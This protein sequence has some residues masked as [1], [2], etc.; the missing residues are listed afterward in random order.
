LGGTDGAELLGGTDG[1]LLL[2]A[3]DVMPLAAGPAAFLTPSARTAGGEADDE[4]ADPRSLR[5]APGAFLPM[6]SSS[7]GGDS[8]P[9]G[10]GGVR[11]LSVVI[12]EVLGVHAADF[13]HAGYLRRAGVVEMKRHP[14]ERD[15]ART[16]CT[17]FYYTNVL[18]AGPSDRSVRGVDMRVRCRWWGSVLHLQGRIG[19]SPAP[20]EGRVLSVWRFGPQG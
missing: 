17:S 8:P 5:R 16:S 1:A 11:P 9:D 13:G 19:Q 6:R 7:A 3:T 18:S 10:G 4:A 12:R 14:K 20:V 2:G 15:E